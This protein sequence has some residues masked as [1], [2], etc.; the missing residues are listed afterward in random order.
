MKEDLRQQRPLFFLKW[1]FWL[2]DLLQIETQKITFCYKKVAPKSDNVS[3]SVDFNED[4]SF[5]DIKLFWF[6][7]TFWCMSK[8]IRSSREIKRIY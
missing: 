7:E 4:F 2:I 1:S 3:S 5:L 6:Q 8:L